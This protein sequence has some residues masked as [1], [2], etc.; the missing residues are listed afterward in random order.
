MAWSRTSRHKRGYGTAWDKTRPIILKRDNY[1]CQPCRSKGR[2]TPATQVHHKLGKADGG[3]DDHDNLE[4]IC[5][6]CHQAETLRQAAEA[7]GHT[8][9]PKVTIGRDGWPI[10]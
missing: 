9:R 2:V 4:S 5:D 1:L 3:T 6:A 10:R 7:R 8:Y